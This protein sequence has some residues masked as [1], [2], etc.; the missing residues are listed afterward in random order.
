[1]TGLVF[2]LVA[3]TRPDGI[4]FYALS[5]FFL[6]LTVS[7]TP[8]RIWYF[9]IPLI[10]I[11]LPYYLLRFMYYGYPFPNTY[12]AKSVYLSWW[13]QGWDYLLLYI[14]SYYVFLLLPILGVAALIKNKSSVCKIIHLP[15]HFNRVQNSVL[16]SLLFSVVFTVYVIRVGGDFMFARFLIPVTPFMYFLMETFAQRI[17]NRRYLI[18]FVAMACLATFFYRYPDNIRSVTNKIVDERYFYPKSSIEEARWKGAVLKRYLENTDARVVIFGTQAMLAYYAE[19]PTVIEGTNG[20]T[21]VG[22]AHLPIGERIRPGHEKNPP[23]DYFYQRGVNFAFYSG[24]YNSPPP[25]A[26][27]TDIYFEEVRGGIYVYNRDLMRKLKTY[28]EVKFVD[29]EQ[30]LD[31]YIKQIPFASRADVQTDY[32]FF[33]KYYFDHNS[34][35]V[36]QDV[37]IRVLGKE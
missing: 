11:Y 35:P 5:I 18:P 27:L 12:Y 24:G 17:L 31:E 32:E 4:I 33:K 9:L 25:E 6:I 21:D 19:F 15:F 28:P 30:F 29:F 37:F 22:I 7:S 8:R 1:L 26:G 3:L 13:S 16:L 36:R 23:A 2:V 14:K 34:D 10:F 20:L